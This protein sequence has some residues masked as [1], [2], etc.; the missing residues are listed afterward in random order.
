MVPLT[1]SH[2]RAAGIRSMR[3]PPALDEVAVILGR[4]DPDARLVD[5]PDGDRPPRLEDAELLE[6]LGR[7]EWGRGE[8]GQLEQEFA[9]IGVQAE[10][11]I[12]QG[13]SLEEARHDFA[14]V[15]DRAPREVEGTART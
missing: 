6:P 8:V 11:E 14:V 4:V 7:L 2:R 15:R 13:T 1:S 10:V 3:R 12:G 5:D 9:T